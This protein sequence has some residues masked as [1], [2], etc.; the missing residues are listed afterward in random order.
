MKILRLWLLVFLW[1][2]FLPAAEAPVGK[3]ANPR[4]P[5]VGIEIPTA[6]KAQLEK[7]VSDLAWQIENLKGA[8]K[9]KPELLELLPDVQIFCNAVRYAL[10]D[11]IFYKTNDF[12]IAR[13]LLDEGLERARSLG[14]GQAPWTNATGLI[15]RGYQSRLDGSVQPYGLVVPPSYR[16]GPD[17]KSRLDLW[18]HGRNNNGSELSFLADREKNPGEFTP[19]DTIVLHPYGRYCNAFKFAGEVDVFEALED[20]RKHYPIDEN[21]ISVRGFS[22]GGAATWHLAA[23]YAGL[24]AVASP[25]AGFVDTAIFQKLIRQTNAPPWYQERLWHL[26][27]ITDCAGNLFNCP[28]V[29]YSGEIDPQRQAAELMSRAMK[30]EGLDLVH[31]IGPNTAHKFEPNA[32]KEVARRV[33]ALMAQGRNPLPKEVRFTTWSLRYNQMGWVTVDGLEHHWNIARVNA[34]ISGEDS[35][36]ITTTNVSALTLSMPAGLCPLPQGRAPRV[37]LDGHQ[38]EATPVAGDRSWTAHFR[39]GVFGWECVQSADDGPLRKRHGLQGPIDDAFMDSFIMVQPTRKAL[40]E[41]VDAWATNAMANAAFEWRMQF[42]GEPRI[43]NDTDITDADI[44]ANNLIL[45]GD[46]YSN[47]LIGRITRELPIHWNRTGIDYSGHRFANQEFVPVLIYPNPLNP[48]H[49]VVI[50]SG[51][52]FVDAA[53]TSNALQVPELPDFT[54]VDIAKRS[55]VDAGFFDEDWKVPILQ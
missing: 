55:I 23:H 11:N 1:P 34:E 41:R 6:N 27:D 5:P 4:M 24:W 16:A 32:K 13:K 2:A 35:I 28:I 12:A 44:A 38:L 15:V 40:N 21:R 18:F 25:G 45:W 17:R 53:P 48:K 30:A 29:A 37:T 22:M 20:V 46:P 51:F 36:H 26:Y 49:Y 47:R 31:I 3:R 42:R 10:E 14:N 7:G 50:N 43:K 8:L 9:S 33:D 52:T 54:I 39:K 19:E